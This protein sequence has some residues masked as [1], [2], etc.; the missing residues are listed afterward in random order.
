[1]NHRQ[2]MCLGL[3]FLIGIICAL[4]DVRYI[5]PKGLSCLVFCV[6]NDDNSGEGLNDDVSGKH[7]ME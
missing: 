7:G 5:S 1:M 4:D 2:R 6:L 3:K